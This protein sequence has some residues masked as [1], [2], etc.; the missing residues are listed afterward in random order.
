MLGTNYGMSVFG[1][2]EKIGTTYENSLYNLLAKH[3]RLLPIYWKWS[4]AS[5]YASAESGR[6]ITEFL[7]IRDTQ[8]ASG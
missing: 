4:L 6:A 1:V 3:K 7:I 5:L 2:A 8:P